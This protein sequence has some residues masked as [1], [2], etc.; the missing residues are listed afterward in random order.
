M[1]RLAVGDGGLMSYVR[2][3]RVEGVCVLTLDRPA[4][5]N[6][7]NQEMVVR[8]T[9]LI[10]MA[11]ADG[12]RAIMLRGEGSSFCA[13]ADVNVLALDDLT[14]AREYLSIYRRLLLTI[15]RLPIPVV[16]AIHG[17]AV[18]AGAEISFE[19]DFRVLSED[20]RIGFPDVA[21]GSTPATVQRMVRALGDSVARRLVLL[22]EELSA[23]EASDTGLAYGVLPSAEACSDA[24]FDLAKRM[25]NLPPLAVEMAKR[26][27]EFGFLL[28]AEAETALNVDAMTLCQGTEEQLEG[29]R[30]FLAGGEAEST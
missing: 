7:L 20:A 25:Q 16:A 24:A 4:K 26:G 1:R 29:A 19:A 13:G 3:K 14:A 10:R 8:L 30:A 5:R 28:D 23:A 6:A 11:E 2:Y 18:G 17:Y 12:G 15:R 27:L 21:L 22:G 9:E